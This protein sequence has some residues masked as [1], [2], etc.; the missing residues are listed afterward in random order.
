MMPSAALLT[1]ETPSTQ[2]AAVRRFIPYAAVIAA[3]VALTAAGQQPGPVPATRC[4]TQPEACRAIVNLLGESDVAG[5]PQPAPSAARPALE[6]VEQLSDA[7][8]VVVWTDDDA[9]ELLERASARLTRWTGSRLRAMD[10]VVGQAGCECLVL[11]DRLAI[12]PAGAGPA[13]WRA[14]NQWR[15]VASAD[16]VPGTRRAVAKAGVSDDGH[17]PRAAGGLQSA[18]GGNKWRWDGSDEAW[19]DLV[20][21]ARRRGYIIG[22]PADR[23]ESPSSGPARGESRVESSAQSSRISGVKAEGELTEVV[24]ALRI[25]NDGG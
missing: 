10:D 25:L 11:S 7:A 17:A 16:R 23:R 15:R 19:S 12:V 13:A 14:G 20:A 6:W 21:A 3:A 2:Y 22:P 8:Q 5:K 18:Q 24:E 1:T 9:S 4:A